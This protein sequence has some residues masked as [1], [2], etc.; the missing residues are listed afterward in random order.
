M[1]AVKIIIGLLVLLVVVVGGVAWY[2][3]SNLDAF[4]EEMIESTGSDIAK[5]TVS[6]GQVVIQPTLLEGKGAI[7]NLSVA[8]PEGY[9]ANSLFSAKSIALQIDI[10][11]I[12]QNKAVKVIKSVSVGEISL[13]AEQKNIKDTNIQALLDNLGD[14]SASDSSSNETSESDVRIMIETL[15]F[16]ATTIDLQTEKFGGKTV[17]LPAFTLSNIGDKTT[18][19]TP[20]QAGQQIAQQLMA[21]VKAAVKSELSQLLTDEAKEKAKEKLKEKLEEKLKGK[22]STDQLK[23]LFK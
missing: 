13:L 8:N 9:S 6:V 23:S 1:K 5:T 10:E 3:L 21:K 2:G 14:T 15:S 16:A 11:S 17:T 4:V 7:Y 12:T 20:A 19:L 18:G 22:I